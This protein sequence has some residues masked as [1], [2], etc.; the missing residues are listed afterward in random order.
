[1]TTSTHTLVDRLVGTYPEL[2]TL[3][4][5][6]LD[7]FGEMFPHVFFGALTA[8]LADAYLADPNAGPEATWRQILADLEREY[9]TGD[10]NVKELLYVSF[11]ENLPYPGQKG[12]Q[13]AEHLGPRLTTDLVDFR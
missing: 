13:I 2:Q 4:R 12:A 11:L 3:E 5:E 10:T 8:W 1:M 9:E 7:A 6:H